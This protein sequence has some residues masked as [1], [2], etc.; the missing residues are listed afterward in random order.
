MGQNVMITAR[1]GGRR[2]IIR[3]LADP[4]E[5]IPFGGKTIKETGELLSYSLDTDFNR[6]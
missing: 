2:F 1:L 3:F 4:A 6:C 5:M